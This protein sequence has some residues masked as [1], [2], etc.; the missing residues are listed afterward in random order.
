MMIKRIFSSLFIFICFALP[1][2]ASTHRSVIPDSFQNATPQE[3]IDQLIKTCRELMAQGKF[4][5]ITPKAEEA[6]ALSQQLGDKTRQARSVMQIAIAAFHSGQSDLAIEKFK[7][8]AALAEQAGDN[9]LQSLSLNSAATLLT[10]AA[11][12]EEALFF[13]NQSLALRRQLNDPRG[14]ALILVMMS[15]LYLVTSDFAK[16][17]Q[18][19]QHALTI[20]HEMKANGKADLQLE[21]YILLKT[22]WG[23]YLRGNNGAALAQVQNYLAQET[24]RTSGTFKFEARD[25]LGAIYLSMGEYE[26]AVEAYSD[27]LEVARAL[28]IAVSQ[29]K[30]MGFLGWSQFQLGKPQEAL[31][32]VSQAL[33]MLRQTGQ[34][35]GESILLNYLA[36]IQRVLKQEEAALTSFRQAIAIIDQQRTRAIPTEVS[37]GSMIS[38]NH[39][40]FSGA[41]DLLISLNR[42]SEA[43]EVAEAY[44]ARA[45]LDVLA[46]S[47]IDLRK[48]LTLAQSRREETIF[49]RISSLQKELWKPGISAAHE[50]QL[51]KELQNAE[52]ELEAF[53]VEMRYTSPRYANVKYVQPIKSE[54]LSKELLDA[55]T[56]LV[57]F[58]LDEKKSFAWVIYQGKISSV[59]LPPRKEIDELVDEYRVVLADKVSALT[60]S[61]AIAKINGRGFELY[62]KVFAPLEDKLTSARKLIIVADGALVYLPFETLVRMNPA[63]SKKNVASDYL[64]DRFIISYAPSA[65]ALAAMKATT[66]QTTTQPK[67]IIAFGD[68]VY[69]ELMSSAS[70]A[71]GTN[72]GKANQLTERGF[73]LRQLPYTRTEVNAITSMFSTSERRAYLGAEAQEE[74]VKTEDLSGYR[75]VHF[76][77]HGMIDENHPARSAIVLSVLND[78]KE[79]GALQMSEVMRL[80]LNADLVTLSACRTGLGKLLNGE[81]MI[82]LTRAFLYA[83]A[84]SVVV[85]LWNVNDVATAELMK[86]FYKNLKQ[87][88]AKDAALRQAKLE[89]LKGQKRAWQ[90]PHFWAPFVLI[91]ER[92]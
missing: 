22:A 68:P 83:G 67:G 54:R 64:V 85:S 84:D 92:E 32:L 46:E 13:F 73:E 43:F 62:Q 86:V 66:K 28:K 53:Q 40:V 29:A 61:S 25:Q 50:S 14:E 35:V 47:K 87:G 19:L 81:G 63:T 10:T 1:I 52:Q 42:P 5:E 80:K 58:V 17:E 55:D 33:A 76:A 60:V 56:A 49:N 71:G 51:K 59:V 88:M 9:N 38:K 44:H 18:L 4:D 39:T 3:R 23:E 30:A 26:K 7:Q 6:L 31:N 15:E 69:T 78:S 2:V 57:E 16:G 12:Y 24:E 74:R 91:G 45:F 72:K 34:S 8:S 90:H 75:Y 70:T 11:A 82:G 65:S 77:A 37:K 41:I 27:A 36:E 48:G 89:L 21:A 20:A 79:D